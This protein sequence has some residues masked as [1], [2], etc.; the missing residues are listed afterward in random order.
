M[1]QLRLAPNQASSMISQAVEALPAEVCG[2]MAGTGRNVTQLIPIHNISQTPQRHFEMDPAE[3]LAAL[4]HVD[5][6]GQEFLGIYHSHPNSDTI[7]S[8]ADIEAVRRA[9]SGTLSLI[10]S[11]RQGQRSLKLWH[12]TPEAVDDCELLIQDALLSDKLPAG[13]ISP[14]QRLAIVLAAF[15]AS[16][17]LIGLSIQLLPPAPDLTRSLP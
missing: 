4:R 8:Q 14:A 13:Q 11:L 12:I 2:I 15:A 10:V 9:M 5:E 17:L 6:T 3:L 7:P 1:I 16:L